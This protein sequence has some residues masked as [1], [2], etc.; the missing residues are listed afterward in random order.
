M[1]D[2][3]EHHAVLPAQATFELFQIKRPVVTA[4]RIMVL[5][6]GKGWRGSVPDIPDAAPASA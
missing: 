2:L 4:S 3:V 5:G 6:D 1:L